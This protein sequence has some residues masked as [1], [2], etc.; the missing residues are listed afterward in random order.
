MTQR[1]V[2][3]V[4]MAALPLAGCGGGDTTTTAPP[5]DMAMK[6][7][8]V[9]SGAYNVSNI[10]KI[11]DGC[12]MG[13]EKAG[14]FTMIQVTNDGSGNL[15]LGGMCPATGGPPTCNPPGYLNGTGT[16]TDSYHA[17]TMVTTMV[18][19]DSAGACTYNRTR[20][21]MVTVTADNTLQIDFTNAASNIAAG[22]QVPP[23][24]P[25]SCTSHYTYTAG[26]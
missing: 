4:M 6:I 16:F 12:M 10:M 15:S 2:F 7:F 26:M 9:V 17:T 13:L 1:L 5:A 19:A 3:A 25:S 21:N 20:T 24:N 8:K 18:T 11:S 14:V 23:P 22:C